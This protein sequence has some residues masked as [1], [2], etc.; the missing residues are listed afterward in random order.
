MNKTININLAGIIFHLDEGAYESFKDYLNQ[1]KNALDSQEGGAEII[2]DI[3]ARIAE[4]FSMRMV[5]FKR[6]A[7]TIEDVN[8]IQATLGAPQDFEDDGDEDPVTNAGIPAGKK[9]L[10]RNTDETIIGGVASGI[11]AYFGTDVVWIRIIFLVLLFFT[12][13]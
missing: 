4:L 8:F 2:A 7:I 1:V 9:R 5:E 10:F 11:A 6:E 13:V 12:G 3:E